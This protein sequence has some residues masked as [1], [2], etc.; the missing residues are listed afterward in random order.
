MNNKGQAS[1][2][3]ILVTAFVIVTTLLIVVMWLNG[4]G[5]TFII[6]KTKLK[7]MEA[8]DQA[9][10]NYTLRKIEVDSSSTATDLVLN[11]Y[12]DPSSFS[13]DRP[14]LKDSLESSLESELAATSNYST[15]AVNFS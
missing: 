13:A 4:L 15:V 6:G 7:T 12:I 2:E 10:E 8:L 1:L 14:D 9:S 5:D 11:L 3:I